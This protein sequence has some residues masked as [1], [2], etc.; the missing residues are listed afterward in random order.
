MPKIIL[1]FLILI[2]I[3]PQ[4][5]AQDKAAGVSF[6][7]AVSYYR[8]GNLD[9]AFNKAQKAF[10]QFGVVDDTVF[11]D[12]AVLC[13]E[14]AIEKKNELLALEWY[15]RIPLEQLYRSRPKAVVSMTRLCMRNEDYGKVVE[16]TSFI[17]ESRLGD[18]VVATLKRYG[19]VAEWRLNAMAN[20]VLF[21]PA[22]LGCHVNTDADEFINS[23]SGDGR[24][25]Y[26]TRSVPHDHFR[27]ERIYFSTQN[28][29][30]WC[31]AEPF[32]PI[33]ENSGA[34]T[35]SSDG[36]EA[37]FV[38][39]GIDGCDIFRIDRNADGTWSKPEKVGKVST[40]MYESQP[41]LSS[42]GKELYFV[43]GKNAADTHL[44]VAKRTENH[45][46]WLSVESTGIKTCDGDNPKAP[47]IQADMRTLYF[48][49]EGEC[50]MG[51]TD[52]FMCRR[53]VD[54]QWDMPLNIGFPLNTSGDE[55]NIVVSPDGKTG[56][57]SA[58]RD[59]G[60]GGYDIYSFE[61]PDAMREMPLLK[62]EVVELK[63]VFFAFDSDVLDA[64]SDVML[65]EVAAFLLRHRDMVV[66]VGG[67][68]DNVGSEEYNVALSL[69]RAESV[70]Q[71]LMQRG[72][73]EIRI[74]TA[75]YGSSK[76][77]KDNDT[78]ESRAANRRIEMK[79][80]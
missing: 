68:T 66:E 31:D 32:S 2:A 79:V 47:F 18:D 27:T 1:I 25:I 52:V 51:G 75:G 58:R 70:K 61:L 11:A 80:L 10:E 30:I 13:A 63:D 73:P 64:S 35:M 34:I 19:N 44:F 39:S 65:D 26:F 43:R 55:M 33:P 9:K 17:E 41:S 53:N 21:N 78:E 5:C 28:D 72:V 23:I 50:G 7:K 49:A 57:I 16:I 3:H 67:H 6:D 24:T 76:P 22:N 37:Y 15:F 60:F 48:S 42:D 36:T 29:G 69:R 56:F 45:G 8:Q 62:D 59:D 4:L 74:K 54:N 40:N 14:I 77:L 46:E 38:L 12:A 71:A 20:P